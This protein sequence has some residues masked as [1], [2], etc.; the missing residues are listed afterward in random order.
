MIRENFENYHKKIAIAIGTRLQS[1][2]VE[3]NKIN[4]HKSERLAPLLLQFEEATKG[5]KN[6][7]G[8]LICLSYILFLD[9]EL[10]SNEENSILDVAVAYE[11]FQ[12]AI[13]AHDDVIDQ[14]SQR[15]GKAT[16]YKQLGG[17]H[18]AI[19]QTIC[20]GDL[21]FLDRRAHV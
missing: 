7:R 11:I 5:G 10:S 3:W 16:L 8:T 9:K 13:L 15:R 1:F 18:Y 21:G 20:I 6:L 19:S 14:S 2:Y 4:I 12:T 17:D